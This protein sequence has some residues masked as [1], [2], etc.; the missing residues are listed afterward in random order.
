AERVAVREVALHQRF[1]YDDHVRFLAHLALGEQTA[2]DER[3]LQAVE[4]AVVDDA[5]VRNRFLAGGRRRLANDAEASGGAAAGER[6]EA[7]EARALDAGNGGEARRERVEELDP[8]LI[9]R[10]ARRR[11]GQPRGEHMAAV[12]SRVDAAQR[13]EAAQ[14][15]ARADEQHHGERHFGDDERL[16]DAAVTQAAADLTR[17]IFE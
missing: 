1:A 11:N 7:D 3:N 12:E 16:T 9:V 6:Q 17:A 10:V 5:N 8:L 15:Q 4:E 14:H 2:A 13:A